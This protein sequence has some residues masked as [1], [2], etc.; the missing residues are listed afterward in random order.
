MAWYQR[1]R[2]ALRSERLS[3]DIER[4][5]SFHVAERADELIARGMEPA[6]AL[7]EARRRF[8]NYTRQK[9]ETRAI[10]LL[11][12]LDTLLGDLRYSLRALRGSP[13]F[14]TVAI[15]SLALGIGANTA[16]FSL[17]HAILLRPLPVTNPEELLLVTEEGSPYSR[18]TNPL[19]EE[20]RARQDVFS[21]MLAYNN[22]SF[23]LA[24]SGEVDSVPGAF[25]SGSFFAT[26][27]VAPALGRVLA[28]A[29]DARGCSPLAV[30]S[31]RF[32][33]S[34]F[35]SDPNVVGRTLEMYGKRFQVIGVSAAEFTGVEVGTAMDIYVP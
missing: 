26:L 35:N 25:V 13:A 15:L 33:R 30:I 22:A 9:E 31:H 32:W 4:E 6:A 2:N 1:L 23:N 21:S 24:S 28:S 5:L 11:G 14:A 12:W 8:G 3:H 18:F 19:W 7:R 20:L 29:D 34:R 10:N 17:L 27:G 16:I